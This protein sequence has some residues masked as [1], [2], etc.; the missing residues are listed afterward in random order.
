V[1]LAS[2]SF[3]TQASESLGAAGKEMAAERKEKTIGELKKN[4]P[5][6]LSKLAGKSISAVAFDK[7]AI[8]EIS[9]VLFKADKA[10]LGRKHHGGGLFVRPNIFE[11][12]ASCF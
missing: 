10:R 1:S 3:S 6:A 9:S 11:K 2:P 12:F 7:L 4:P 5:D 8:A